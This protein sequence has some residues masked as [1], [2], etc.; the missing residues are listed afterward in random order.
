M[1]TAVALALIISCPALGQS[2]KQVLWNYRGKAIDQ[3]TGELLFTAKF[4]EKRI[5]GHLESME[6]Q[7]FDPKT[8]QKIAD[9]KAV[10][11]QP[12]SFNPNFVFHNYRTGSMEVVDFSNQNAALYYKKNQGSTAYKKQLTQIPKPIVADAGLV[13]LVLNRWSD[14][15]QGKVVNLQIVVPSR[16]DY[17][18]FQLCKNKKESNEQTMVIYFTSSNWFIRQLV[19]PI[20]LSFDTR[21]KRLVQYAGT[22]NLTN[23]NGELIMKALIT[24]Q[25]DN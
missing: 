14:L 11:E 24:Y 12:G 25:F 16:L 6:T 7:Y 23:E 19:S 5:N 2:Q 4:T 21:S 22:T 3:Q 17:Y 18:P 15:Q 10:F 1:L 9:R 20:V 8:G 13:E